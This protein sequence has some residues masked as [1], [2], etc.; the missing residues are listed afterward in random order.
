VE[1]ERHV[2]VLC[3]G[4]GVL[5]LVAVVE[6]R[7]GRHD[8]LELEALL[9]ADALKRVGDLGLLRSRLRFVGEVLEAAPPA[10][11]VVLARRV[12]SGCSGLDDL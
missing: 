1:A 12:H 11:G 3:G 10:C 4:E 6:D 8:R 9:A 2:P 5:E 7:L